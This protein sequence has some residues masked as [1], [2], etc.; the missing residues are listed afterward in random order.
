MRLYAILMSRPLCLHHLYL[1][2]A[3]LLAKGGLT[4]GTLMIVIGLI[5]CILLIYYIVI[6]L[7][8]DQS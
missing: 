2:Y 4:M 7:R 8:G 3:R 1:P 5:A 6:L